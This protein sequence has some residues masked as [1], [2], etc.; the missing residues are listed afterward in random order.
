M[1]NKI[2]YVLA[3]ETFDGEAVFGFE[4]PADI[5]NFIWDIEDHVVNMALAIEE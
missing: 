2:T 1:K 4:D 3:V 5:T